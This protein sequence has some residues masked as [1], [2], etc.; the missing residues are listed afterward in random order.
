MLFF[1]NI[2]A[3]TVVP[4]GG[5]ACTIE[6]LTESIQKPGYCF[7]GDGTQAVSVK[8]VAEGARAMAQAAADSATVLADTPESETRPELRAKAKG[9]PKRGLD[10]YFPRRNIPSRAAWSSRVSSGRKSKLRICITHMSRSSISYDAREVTAGCS[11]FGA[12]T[13]YGSSLMPKEMMTSFS[14][15]TRENGTILHGRAHASGNAGRRA[16]PA[17]GDSCVEGLEAPHFHSHLASAVVCF[18]T[19]LRSCL[20]DVGL[21]NW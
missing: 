21:S 17:R 5:I 11:Y 13:V 7:C 12:V 9:K 14:G 19:P 8:S 2:R 10:T 20:C 1:V 15:L 6:K 18:C 4:V 3:E 16:S